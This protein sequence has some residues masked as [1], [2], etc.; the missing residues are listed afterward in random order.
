MEETVQDGC[1]HIAISD[2]HVIFLSRVDVFNAPTRNIPKTA[3]RP[4][5]ALVHA[6]CSF[7]MIVVASLQAHV[8]TV[9][10]K[11]HKSHLTVLLPMITLVLAISLCDV[12]YAI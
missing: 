8:S 10:K 4:Y 7:R 1:R 9:K 6:D 12:E 3:A 5:P 11:K 2:P